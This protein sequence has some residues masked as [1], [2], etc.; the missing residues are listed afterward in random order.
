MRMALFSSV[1]EITFNQANV[2]IKAGVGGQESMLFVNTLIDIYCNLANKHKWTIN[3]IDEDRTDLGG[4]RHSCLRIRG[5]ECLTWMYLE[6]GVHRVQRVPSTEK[7]GRMHTSTVAVAVLPVD[8]H[9]NIEV[10]ENDIKVWTFSSRGPGGQ[11]ANKTQSGVRIQH[12][13]SGIT[14]TRSGSRLQSANKE[15]A[16]RALQI[17]LADI[18]SNARQSIRRQSIKNQ[19]GHFDRNEKIR[20]YNFPQDRVTDHRV[21]ANVFNLENYFNAD[22]SYHTLAELTANKKIDEW[23]LSLKK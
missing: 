20:T 2:E 4:C 23:L 13:P 16:I 5:D 21:P 6:S 18:Q 1:G 17:S 7:S 8:Q 11:H 15:E 22:S 10:T 12:I 9:S 3:V 14:I 19:F